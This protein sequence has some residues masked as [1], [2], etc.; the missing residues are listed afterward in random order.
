MNHYENV[1]IDDLRSFIREPA[2][3]TV[4]RSADAAERFLTSLSEHD[5]VG[6]LWLDHDLGLNER[7]E[8]TEVMGF[9]RALEERLFEGSAPAIN[10][11][12]IHTSNPVG[13]RNIEAALRNKLQCYRV[14][15][16]DYFI[17]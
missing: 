3:T 5:S 6:T 10:R 16:G 4:L 9:V 8:P 12:M 14:N 15:A 17:A 1:L 13:A 7:D 11:V 2:G